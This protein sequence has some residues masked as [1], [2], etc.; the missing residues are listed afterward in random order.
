MQA[1]SLRIQVQ[2]E[3]RQRLSERIRASGRT[4]KKEVEWLLHRALQ[5]LDARAGALGV[6]TQEVA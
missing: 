5:E 2:P 6:E 4:P 3:D 1:G